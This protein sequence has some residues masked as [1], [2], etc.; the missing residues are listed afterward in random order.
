MHDLLSTY[1]VFPTL[2]TT[3]YM[4]LT[5]LNVLL[6]YFLLFTAYSLP[7]YCIPTMPTIMTTCC[8]LSTYIYRLFT[9]LLTIYY[10][11]PTASYCLVC[12]TYYLKLFEIYAS[13]YAIRV[14]Y[15]FCCYKDFFLVFNFT[16]F[17]VVSSIGITDKV[18]DISKLLLFFNLIL[19]HENDV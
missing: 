19:G 1:Y 8:I 9:Y 15:H 17:S 13:M 12:N 16:P 4:L 2:S 11:I 14:D 3:K 18:K 7:T 10:L 6:T 5:Y